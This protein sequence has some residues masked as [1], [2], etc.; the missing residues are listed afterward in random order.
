MK[1]TLADAE[2]MVKILTERYWAL[3]QETQ[4]LARALE[5]AE[6][7]TAPRPKRDAADLLP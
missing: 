2:R 3:V 7:D 5:R 6:R 4:K 1:G